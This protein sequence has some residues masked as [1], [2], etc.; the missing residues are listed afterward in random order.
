MVVALFRLSTRQ[1]I[2]FDYRHGFL[3]AICSSRSQDHDAAAVAAG[4]DFICG[5]MQARNAFGRW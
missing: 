4:A 3:V 1:C 2:I 5:S